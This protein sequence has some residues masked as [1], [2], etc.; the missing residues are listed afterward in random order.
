MNEDS[1]LL[2][3]F[4]LA[5]NVRAEKDIPYKNIRIEITL[6]NNEYNEIHYEVLKSSGQNT[7]NTANLFEVDLLDIIFI[8]KRG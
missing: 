1:K 6:P 2:T 4:N 3:Y 5:R 7:Q 8:F